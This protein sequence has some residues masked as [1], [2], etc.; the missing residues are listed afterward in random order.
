MSSM[1]MTIYQ[2]LGT[3]SSSTLPGARVRRRQHH[4]DLPLYNY[5][6]KPPL[7]STVQH[8]LTQYFHSNFQS[9]LQ[10]A[11]REAFRLRRAYV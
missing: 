9:H 2:R 7:R 5:I 8:R 3:L 1:Q 6:N 11:T 10:C 4:C